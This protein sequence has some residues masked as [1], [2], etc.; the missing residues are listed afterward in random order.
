MD[1]LS[2][3][4]LNKIANEV[5]RH[6]YVILAQRDPKDLQLDERSA[7]LQRLWTRLCAK[8]NVRVGGYPSASSE[9]TREQVFLKKLKAALDTHLEE[10][11]T[12]EDYRLFIE[13]FIEKAFRELKGYPV[14]KSQYSDRK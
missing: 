9:P 8:M 6:A 14:L 13:S 11:L 3:E 7:L 1:K 5:A 2:R 10:A 4:E 12:D